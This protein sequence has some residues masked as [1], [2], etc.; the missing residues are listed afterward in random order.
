MRYTEFKNVPRLFEFAQGDFVMPE[1]DIIG[2]TDPATA[3]INKQNALMLLQMEPDSSSMKEITQLLAQY[4]A[5]SGL[6]DT[7][8]TAEPTAQP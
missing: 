1:I 4:S 5:D 7:E 8:Q 6:Q 3:A 2:P